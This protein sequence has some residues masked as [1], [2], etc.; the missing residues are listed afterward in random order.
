M[1]DEMQKYFFII[2]L[3]LCVSFASISVHAAVQDGVRPDEN[4]LATVLS[5]GN[6]PSA[7]QLLLTK[8]FPVQM[9]IEA[10]LEAGYDDEAITSAIY[11]SSLSLD[12]VILNTMQ[13]H[14][15]SRNVLA[16]LIKQG[17]DIDFIL[18]TLIQNQADINCILSTF[19]FIL[20]QDDSKYQAMEMLINAGADRDIVLRVA[21]HFNVP[22][23]TVLEAYRQIYGDFG[24][25]GHVYN[26]HTM[27][28]PALIAVGVARINNCDAC[29]NRPAISPYRP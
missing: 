10:A 8:N 11:Q 16:R 14:L 6:L 5:E 25:F 15:R 27:P 22:P 24:Q 23:A 28:Q 12:K 9:I 3:F 2:L 13:S 17:L 29:R 1:E 18:Q 7:V 19:Q 26:R 4:F 20:N 21:K